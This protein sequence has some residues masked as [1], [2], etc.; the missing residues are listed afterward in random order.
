MSANVT[1]NAARTFRCTHAETLR[2][3]AVRSSTFSPNCRNTLSYRGRTARNSNRTTGHGRAARRATARRRAGDGR[4]V[5]AA[6]MRLVY[7][8]VFGATATATGSATATGADGP[9]GRTSFFIRV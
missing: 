2:M 1:A 5:G 7:R 9:G 6:D 8:G 3:T 4:G